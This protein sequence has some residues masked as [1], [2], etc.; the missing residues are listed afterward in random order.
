[1]SSATAV[2]R[3]LDECVVVVTPR[4]FGV[5]DPGL[6]REL[7]G[8]VGRVLYQTGPLAAGPL[9]E[10]VREADGLIAGLDEVSADVFAAAHRLRVVARY[11]VGTDRVDL[12][13]ARAG[14]VT[15]TATPG[16]NSN[17]VAELAVA[18]LFALA[19]PLFEGRQAAR[20]ERWPALRGVELSGRALGVVGLGRIGS[21]VAGKARALGMTVVAYDPYLPAQPSPGAAQRAPLRDGVDLV[22]LPVLLQISDFV[23]LH[24]PLTEETRGMLGERQF[25]MM[26]PG[27]VVVN[28]AR[29]P[30]I[31]EA[32]LLWAL[33]EGPLR[34]AALDVLCEEPPPPGSPGRLLLDREDVIVM[35][36]MGP[37]TAE[38]TSAMG[39]AA[40]DELI[41]VLSGRAP[42]FA[43]VDCG[44]ARPGAIVPAARSVQVTQP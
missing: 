22:A 6:R 35:P 31:D 33:D 41:A 18:L 12:S 32:A 8:Q 28:T 25:A 16:A 40:V 29:G 15:V 27:A 2:L 36:H 43:V 38:A 24:A 5:D 20:G 14:G 42:R 21:L 13:A 23:S 10:A 19:R 9:A 7:E 37:H 1:M 26:K 39:R 30:L 11:G 3:P 17:A 44:P 34:A 4:S